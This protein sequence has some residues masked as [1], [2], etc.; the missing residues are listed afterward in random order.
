MP[1]VRT[2]IHIGAPPE[3][4]DRVLLD[5]ELAPVWT[6]GLERLEV[7][8]GQP[9]RPGCVGRAHYLEG[10][11]RYV[12]EDVLEQVT[13]AR[14]YLSRVTGGG[15]TASVETT[16]EPMGE[17]RTRL[18]L[19]WVGRGTTLLTRI[20]L[21]FMGRRIRRRAEADLRALRGLAESDRT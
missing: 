17:G 1:T 2:T 20:L 11:R 6:S 7:V 14:H 4:V 21:P 16:L 12:L 10:G 3:A 18:T 9:G 8:A 5:A 15:I 19:R 13:P